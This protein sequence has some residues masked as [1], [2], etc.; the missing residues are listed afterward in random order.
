VLG[1]R[2]LPVVSCICP[3]YGRPDRH[4]RAY[5]C[6]SSLSYPRKELLV[7]DDSQ[8]PSRFFMTLRDPRVRYWH[9]PARKSVGRKRNELISLA[10]GDVIQHQDDDDHYAPEYTRVMVD[11]LLDADLVKLSVFNILNERDNSRWM[12]DTRIS[13]G[14][15]SVLSAKHSG[16]SVSLPRGWADSDVALW[17]FGFSYVYRRALWERAPFPDVNLREDYEFIKRARSVGG[18]LKHIA[19]C[20][21][22]VWHSVHRDSMSTTFPQVRLDSGMQPTSVDVAG[23]SVAM[24]VFVGATLGGPVGALA[25]GLLARTA[26][27]SVVRRLIGSA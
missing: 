22:L 25:G 3:T 6:F 20:P 21:Y 15:Q 5:H 17:G 7:L 16:L 26:A 10:Q 24:G 27:R 23:A 11:H 19:D 13:G 2:A 1:S 14:A 4:Q 12:W 18:R 8:S 9:S